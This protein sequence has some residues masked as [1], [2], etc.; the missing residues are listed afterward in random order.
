MA[1]LRNILKDDT[2]VEINKL[3]EQTNNRA[4]MHIK[5][6]LMKD[7]NHHKEF[8][9]SKASNMARKMLTE[10]SPNQNMQT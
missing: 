3:K 10:N 4:Y 2:I 8:L 1:S 6:E 9:G 5:Q 7:I